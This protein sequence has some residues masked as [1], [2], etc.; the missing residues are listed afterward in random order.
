MNGFKN[1][2]QSFQVV[3]PALL[4]AA[5]ALLVACGAE[6][7]TVT[8]KKVPAVRVADITDLTESPF[9]G[10]AKAGQEVN[11]SFRVSGP[12]VD[13]PV[14]V[15][16]QVNQGDLLV[17]ID[18]KDYIN[19]LGTARGQL[20]RAEAAATRAKSDY[21]RIQRVYKA[22]PGATSETA[23]DLAL[24]AQDS[25]KATVNSLQ[26]AVSAAE[27]QLKYTSLRAPFAG[28]IVSTYVDNYETVVAKQPI[29][30]LLDPSSIEFVIYVPESSISYVPYVESISVTFD[31]AP[32]FSIPAT[33]KEVGREASQSTRTYPVTLVM[34]QP[35]GFEILPGMSGSALVSARLP[36][37]AKQV[38]IE[39]PAT[40][41]FSHRDPKKSFVWVM[42]AS[43]EGDAYQ[44]NRREVEVGG[45][46]NS[47][48]IIK[49]GIEVGDWVVVRGV[50]SI[51]EGQNVR[52][53]D[54]SDKG[55]E[56]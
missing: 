34:S 38:G 14:Q 50:N 23:V 54:Y 36:K 1:V 30:R 37:E 9:P 19:S 26:S 41:I 48:A 32:N 20:E 10:K 56:Q 24:A 44:V 29:L 5:L 49:S 42:T 52:L 13:F 21:Q 12:L 46:S 40:A 45:L 31:A 35:E 4:C 11:L 18:P 28:E 43:A 53:D 47:G 8:L 27:D 39:L 16:D 7:P 15:G 51:T 33:I 22:D 2:A 3:K 25:S 6:P 55:S 17:R